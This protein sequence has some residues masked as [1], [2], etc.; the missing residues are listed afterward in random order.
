M[1]PQTLK[2][3]LKYCQR[4]GGLFDEQVKVATDKKLNLATTQLAGTL[5]GRHAK[6][7]FFFNPVGQT[8]DTLDHL[9][10]TS[11]GLVLIEKIQ[12]QKQVS[13]FDHQW[14][15]DNRTG[16]LIP[17]ENYRLKQVAEHLDEL[18]SDY[19][20]VDIPMFLYTVADKSF[21]QNVITINELGSRAVSEVRSGGMTLSPVDMQKIEQVLTQAHQMAVETKI[22]MFNPQFIH[23]NYN[24][25]KPMGNGKHIQPH[26]LTPVYKVLNEWMYDEM[27][28]ARLFHQVKLAGLPSHQNTLQ[29]VIVSSKGLLLFSYLES[30]V[31]IQVEIGNPTWNVARVENG[32]WKYLTMENPIHLLEKQADQFL[33]QLNAPVPTTYRIIGLDPIDIEL[34]HPSLI[35][36]LHLGHALNKYRQESDTVLNTEQLNW[37][38]QQLKK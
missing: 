19:V 26:P 21:V 37:I 7:L 16:K 5:Q 35:L 24:P 12:V 14:W 29:T 3:L 2:E 28:E 1:R 31:K 27:S 18:L 10:I 11:N 32:G 8:L 9:I 6:N 33:R 20:S 15:Q 38:K 23:S 30:E 4:K 13:G 36:E 17:N 25:L 34:N 22:Q